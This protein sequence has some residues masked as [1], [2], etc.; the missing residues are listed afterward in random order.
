MKKFIIFLFFFGSTM[1]ASAQVDEISESEESS[2]DKIQQE[3][4]RQAQINLE[5]N[6]RIEMQ[7]LKNERIAK[8]KEK[9]LARKKAKKSNYPL[10]N[11]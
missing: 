4:P 6:V 3:P 11:L 1:L 2:Q 10:Q 5:R 8:R 9:K 7:R